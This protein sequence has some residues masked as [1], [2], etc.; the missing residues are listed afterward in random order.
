M[1]EREKT[2]KLRLVVYSSNSS[3]ILPCLDHPLKCCKPE[4]AFVPFASGEEHLSTRKWKIIKFPRTKS[5]KINLHI[6]GPWSIALKY[7]RIIVECTWICRA[8]LKSPRSSAWQSCTSFSAAFLDMSPLLSLANK[9][10]SFFEL[11]SISRFLAGFAREPP[12]ASDVSLKSLVKVVI[13]GFWWAD[14]KSFDK[15]KL[16]W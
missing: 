10:P 5:I 4:I 14:E 2:M 1:I 9:A 11:S 6:R 3:D 13:T 8:V 7:S 12:R 16:D 15:A